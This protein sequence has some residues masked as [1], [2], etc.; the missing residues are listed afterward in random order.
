[1]QE[2]AAALKAIREYRGLRLSE[3]ADLSGIARSY[4]YQLE[5]GESEP[6]VSKLLGLAAAY[7]VPL[8]ELLGL[9]HASG[10]RPQQRTK[11]PVSNE[12]AIR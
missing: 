3:A 5:R 10:H 1:M 11:R 4:L 9:H 12:W 7:D 2:L 8:C 6:T